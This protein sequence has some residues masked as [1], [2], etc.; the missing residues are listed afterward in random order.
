MTGRSNSHP[1]LVLRTRPLDNT[2]PVRYNKPRYEW[3]Y[4]E[5]FY[6]N[7]P[8]SAGLSGAHLGLLLE[9][10]CSTSRL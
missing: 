4:Y 8:H 1:I 7:D 10:T 9:C 6:G 5:E 3:I 2:H